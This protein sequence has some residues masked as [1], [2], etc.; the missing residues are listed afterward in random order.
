MSE[1]KAVFI[2]GLGQDS[3]R[4]EEEKNKPLIIGGIEIEYEKSLQGNSDADPVLHAITNAVSSLT[5]QNILGA[6]ADKLCKEEG[7]VDSSV[8][9][10]HGLKYLNDIE[11]LHVAVSIECLRPK[12]SPHIEGMK[13]R[14]ASLLNLK[15]DQVGITATTGE[16]LTEF[17]KGNGVQAFVI[18]S[19]VKYI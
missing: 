18:I 5:G 8:Y 15:P 1:S 10:L 17:G 19:A 4:F 14:I 3:H 6:Y 16:G 9:L 7:I 11:L 12:I 2:T 13:Q